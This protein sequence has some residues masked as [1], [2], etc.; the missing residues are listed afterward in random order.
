MRRLRV[1]GPIGI[2]AIALVALFIYRLAE[3]D[4]AGVVYA[5]TAPGNQHDPD[6]HYEFGDLPPMGGVHN[7]T[8]QNCGIYTE[9]VLPEHAVHSMEHG[10]VWITYH[11]ELPAA[12][13]E[14]LQNTA[15]GQSYIILSPYPDQTSDIALTTWDIQLQV[16]SASDER[17]QQFIDRYKGRRGPETGASCSGGV[18]NPIQ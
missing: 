17:I 3:P 16:D 10:A 7:P 14:A 1:W 5:D 11:P 8:W 12:Q 9:P 2:I 13:I 4:V 18:G 6:F 15:R